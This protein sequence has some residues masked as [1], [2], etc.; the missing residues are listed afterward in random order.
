MLVMMKS[1]RSRGGTVSRD[2]SRSELVYVIYIIFNSIMMLTSAFK[3]KVDPNDSE[4]LA[5]Y[6]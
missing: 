6:L 3:F 2:L 1:R 4:S 5:A